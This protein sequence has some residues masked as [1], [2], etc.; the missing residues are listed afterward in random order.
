[1]RFRRDETGGKFRPT[2][3]K[4]H[5]YKF[6]KANVAAAVKFVQGK[7]KTGP[8]YS[9]KYSDDLTVK[10]GKL[11]YKDMLVVPLEKT[12][13]ILR[14]EVYKKGGDTPSGRDAAFHILKKRYIGISRRQLMDF[15]RKQRTL[16]ATR[17]S[18]P[19]AK[20]SAGE[21]LKMRTYETDLI[22]LRRNDLENA[23]PKFKREDLK[24]ETYF[25][26]TVEKFTGLFRC[27]YVTT[28]RLSL[29]SC[30]S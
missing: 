17:P 2:T 22:F 1:M 8:V 6:T 3:I 23:N 29:N 19:Q 15:L 30:K 13:Q 18:V 26:S 5:R 4:M 20:Q 25:V 16:G 14:E 21:K 27:A 10:K 28:K 12:E 24:K 9:K 11:F 7:A